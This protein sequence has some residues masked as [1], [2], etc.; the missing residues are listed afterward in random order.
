MFPRRK[1]GAPRSLTRRARTSITRGERIRPSTSIASPSLVGSSVTV[2]HLSCCWH[3]RRTRNRRTIPGSARRVLAVAAGQPQPASSAA[4]AAPAAPP[5]ATAGRPGLGS[6]GSR[7]G[8]EKSGCGGSRSAD[9]AP[10]A[11]SS[12][13]PRPRPWPACGPGSSTP[14]VPPRT[15][16]RPVAPRGHAPG[17]T[18]LDADE[19]A[20]SPVFCGNFLHHL[21]LEIALRN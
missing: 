2:R 5:S 13:R 3:S 10:T 15:A 19:P 7:R 17:C 21:D 20:R 6:Y 12:A 18:Q 11:P 4:C 9:S 8:Q 1:A 14:I 16:C